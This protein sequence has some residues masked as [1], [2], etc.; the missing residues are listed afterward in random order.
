MALESPW[1][2]F[3]INAYKKTFL[4]KS[5]HFALFTAK[6]KRFSIFYYNYLLL[7]ILTH[8]TNEKL[9]NL[10]QFLYYKF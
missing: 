7:F 4:H 8:M 5:Q 3:S 9:H 2:I 1:F 10:F 6:I